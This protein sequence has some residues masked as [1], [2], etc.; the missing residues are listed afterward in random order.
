LRSPK[1]PAEN[2]T[3]HE[4]D[5]LSEWHQTTDEIPDHVD[6]RFCELEAEIDR[7]EAKRQAYDPDD[8]AR[9]GAF[10]ILNHD[11]SLRIER[12]FIRPSDEKREPRQS[13]GPRRRRQMEM[14]VRRAKRRRTAKARR[15]VHPRRKRTTTIRCPTFS[16]ATSPHIGPWAYASV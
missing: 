3:R 7:L 12:G 1:N 6:V 9:G 2:P 15:V 10:V 14:K 11:G 8:V 13:R 5:Q 4:V 16:F